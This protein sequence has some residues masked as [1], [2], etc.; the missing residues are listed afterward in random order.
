MP[1]FYL[2]YVSALR[3]DVHGKIISITVI[4]EPEDDN[5][6]ICEGEGAMFTCVLNSNVGN[7]VQ[8][9]RYMKDTSTTE[10]VYPNGE[11]I[12]IFTQAGNTINSSLSVTNAAKSYTGYYW[13]GTLSVNVCN[14]SLTV[15]TSM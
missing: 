12:F 14:I 15:T 10:I 1:T 2:T 5:A 6:T 11:N 3:E 9:Y 8:W 4:S 13:V 7:D